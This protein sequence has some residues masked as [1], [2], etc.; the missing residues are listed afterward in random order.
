MG[1][2]LRNAQKSLAMQQMLWKDQLVS[3]TL[4]LW[5]GLSAT[6]TGLR[7]FRP[8]AD[9]LVELYDFAV[10]FDSIREGLYDSRPSR[11]GR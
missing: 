1:G 9:D 8:F 10:K 5:C 11:L 3:S 7:F 6:P 4:L 2:G